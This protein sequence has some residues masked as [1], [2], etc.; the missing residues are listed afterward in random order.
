MITAA[1]FSGFYLVVE[2]LLN[3][4]GVLG[5]VSER[6]LRQVCRCAGVQ[7]CKFAGVQ[8]CKCASVQVC[9]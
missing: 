7:V 2:Y 8:V 3:N 4:L 6:A 1:F 9:K 5:L